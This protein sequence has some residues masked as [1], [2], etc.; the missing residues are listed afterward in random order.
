MYFN[1]Q[2][3]R[4]EMKKQI[5]IKPRQTG[6][7]HNAIEVF[8]R[9]K[10]NKLFICYNSGARN[11]IMKKVNEPNAKITFYNSII[12]GALEGQ[13]WDLIVLDEFM[14]YPKQIEIY[15]TLTA[16]QRN[17]NVL[18]MC[19]TPNGTIPQEM[20]DY[21]VASKGVVRGEVMLAHCM[22]NYWID[23]RQFDYWFYNF[24]TDKDSNLV[25]DNFFMCNGDE[26]DMERQLGTEAYELYI[27]NKM[28]I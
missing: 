8:K 20:F 22:S 6:K 25:F 27:K 23:E 17:I 10:G 19:S 1:F 26:T 24:I 15:R 14:F 12:G 3:L 28:I 5:Y 7:T 16:M 21:I 18:Y 2:Y 11:D 13:N 4:K 9:C